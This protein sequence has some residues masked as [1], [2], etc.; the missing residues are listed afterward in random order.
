[1][2]NLSVRNLRA[3]KLKVE[4]GWWLFTLILICIVLL[5]IWRNAPTF[6]FF[7]ENIF[8][9]AAFVTFTRYIF[10]LPTTLIAREKWIKLFIIAI[11]AILFFV[12]ST[13]LSDF[14]NF[15]EEKGLQT[16]VTHLH[17]QAQS[18]VINYIKS[19]M[20]FFGVGSIIAGVIL[21]FRMIV[22]LWRMKNR[23]T[24]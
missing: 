11:A 22:S 21:P 8:L 17:V 3:Q 5:P 12:M 16:L 14:H 18:N 13:A 2:S 10:L 7:G 1:M 4:L 20:I 23:G 24:V 9:I 6:P 19:E 15:L